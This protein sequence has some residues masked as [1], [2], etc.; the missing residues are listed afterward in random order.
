TCPPLS[1]RSYPWAPS[2][3]V[4]MTHAS[5]ILMSSVSSPHCNTFALVPSCNKQSE[6]LVGRA[7]RPAADL[8]VGLFDRKPNQEIRRELEVCSQLENILQRELHF[9]VVNKRRR[10]AAKGCTP[11]RGAWRA[12][13]RRVGEVEAL[14]PELHTMSLSNPEILEQREVPGLLRGRVE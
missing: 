6:G 2:R 13:L 12:E 8:R 10:N 3:P 5:K 4:K 1:S 14:P 7:S 11:Q 9:A